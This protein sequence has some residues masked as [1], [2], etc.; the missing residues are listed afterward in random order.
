MDLFIHLHLLHLSLD[1]D[2]NIS[3]KLVEAKFCF[4]ERNVELLCNF[5]S[6]D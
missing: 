6:Y 3:N 4:H 5:N 2:N 1:K